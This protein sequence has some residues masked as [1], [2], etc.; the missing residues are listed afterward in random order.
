[1]NIDLDIA[2]T[3]SA[4]I[5]PLVVLLVLLAYRERIPLIFDGLAGRV[6]KLKFAGVDLELA[7]AKSYAPTWTAGTFDLRQTATALQVN[8]STARTF[9]SQ[10]CD[11]AGGD[12]AEV[13]LGAGREW[14]TSRLFIMAIVFA[15]M[16]GVRAFVFLDK[17]GD[18]RKRFVCW[19]DIGAVRWALARRY[20]WLERAYAEA[21]AQ[22]LGKQNV[23]V[24]DSQGKLGFQYSQQDPGPSI[25]LLREF[26]QRIESPPAPLPDHEE[27]EW[28]ALDASPPVSEHASWL[29]GELL[30]DLLGKDCNASAVRS[31][32]IRGKGAKEQLQVLLAVPGRY[33]AVTAE[34]GRFEHLVDRTALLEQAAKSV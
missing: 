4:V 12:Y 31:S 20:P 2:A 15:R 17:S 23:F 6:T 32:E 7:S 34:D 8:D 21:Y 25:E 14:L 13:N 11:Q 19:C 29:D 10:L 18:T 3:V 28:I 24:V 33:V 27:K 9:V 16:K 30:E 5:W 22:I 26:L 1:M